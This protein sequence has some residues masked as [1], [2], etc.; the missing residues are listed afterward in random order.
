M[1]GKLSLYVYN[2]AF[3]IVDRST[4]VDKLV[5]CVTQKIDEILTSYT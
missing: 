4:I 2:T 1:D 5:T 3:E